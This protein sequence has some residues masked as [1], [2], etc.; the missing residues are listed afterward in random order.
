MRLAHQGYD[1]LKKELTREK[2][3][4][5][6]ARARIADFLIKEQELDGLAD[7]LEGKG[8]QVRPLS[9]A[10]IAERIRSILRLP[11]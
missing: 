9:R 4:H 10:E 5:V 1:E 11:E 8:Q 2:Q 6:W 7:S 3:E